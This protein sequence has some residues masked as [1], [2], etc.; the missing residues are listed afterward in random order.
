MIRISAPGNV[1]LFGEHAVVYERPA[2][3]A[4]IGLRTYIN[5][6]RRNDDKVRVVS[7]G[8]GKIDSSVDELEKLDYSSHEDYE[9]EMDPLR[10]LI[11]YYFSQL[12][13]PENGFEGKI[14]SDI[15]KDSGGM[16]SS[17]AVIG[18]VMSALNRLYRTDVKKRNF[19]SH[20]YPIQVKIHGG[21]ASGSEITSSTMG[22]YNRFWIER[23][24]NETDFEFKNLGHH[25]YNLVIGDTGIEAPTEET[26]KYVRGGWEKDRE[27]YE[28][29]FDRINDIV[30]EGKEALVNGEAEKV[31]ELMNK[32]QKILRILGVS[33][34]KLERLIQAAKDAGAYG[35]KLSGGGGGGIMIALCDES[36]KKEVAK[37]IEEAGGRAEMTEVGVEGVRVGDE[38]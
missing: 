6:E 20:L 23:S 8:Y 2:I 7:E 21:S 38:L 17:T 16:S 15:P 30:I 28:T 1:F 29:E 13:S 4:A 33:H 26:V 3:V 34:P 9:D 25:S 24:G 12:N 11:G 22:G 36:N 19:F 14:T 18:S 31:G 5:I 32:N 27:S 37:A 10:D 35:A